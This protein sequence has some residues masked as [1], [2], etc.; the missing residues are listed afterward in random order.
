[1]KQYILPALFAILSANTLSSQLVLQ[2]DFESGII[3]SGWTIQTKASDGGWTIGTPAV[4]SSQYWSISANGSNYMA[5]SNDDGCNCDKSKDYFI[6]PPLNFS[7]LSK[8]ALWADVFFQSNS[9]QGSTEH[10]TIEVSYDKQTWTIVNTLHGHPGWDTHIIDLSAYAG[11]D[12]IYIAFH[13]NDGGGWLYGGAI[14]NVIV[15]E[16]SSLDAKMLKVHAKPYG[17]ETIENNIA[18]TIF[19]NGT[20][21]IHSI[22]WSYSLNGGEKFISSES[23]LSIAPFA[24]YEFQHSVPWISNGT[25]LYNVEAE[26][27]LVNG[28]SDEDTT[29]NSLLFQTE[30]FPHI[31][32]PNLIDEI[33]GSVPE[34]STIAT[35]ANQ[36][37]KPTDLDFFSILGKNELW[38]V[39]QR[40]EGSGGSTLTINNAGEANQSFLSRVDG[41]AWHFMSLPTAI[42]FSDNFNFSTAPGIKDAN[43]G[44]GSFTG[45]TLWSS[46]PAI[47][48]QPSGGNGSHIDM[49]HGSPFSMGIASEKDNV[50]WVF[51]GWNGTIVRYDFQGDHGPGNDDHSDGIVRRYMEIQVKKD[52]D[53]PSHMVLDKATGWMYVVDNGN[54]RVLRLD[55]H[56]GSILNSLPFINE[57]LGEHSQM[58]GVNWEVIIQDNLGRPSGIEIKDNRLLVSDYA[59]GDIIIYDI[60]NSFAELGRIITGQPGITGLKIG[61]DGA[62]WYT[63]RLQNTL[64]KVLPGEV[65]ATNEQKLESQISI[66]PNPTTGTLMIRL[67]D[68]ENRIGWTI[69]IFDPAGTKVL[70]EKSNSSAHQL[71]IG[72]LS[73]G[74]YLLSI[75]SD[76]FHVSRKIVLQN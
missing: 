64:T 44:N 35:A 55:I 49:L 18:V 53:I 74:I 19:N 56:S 38:V 23:G 43:H 57:P 30:I 69:E 68:F 25:G 33:L 66:S 52:T 15:K 26:V 29:N 37:D 28:V 73:S 13:Y 62:I 46:D 58:G 8:V 59:S 70:S 76:K 48:A 40:T 12:S 2:E 9:L 34:F 10:M 7:G 4:L 11:Q 36:L 22:L 63:N 60:D 72:N 42:A 20:D 14:D 61:P 16:P 51:D 65:S 75:R 1:M 24:S 6:T 32:A 39:N 31:I 17:E 47:Y 54:H 71:N 67:P 27:N 3:P 45:P 21:S 41:N 50:F 5:A